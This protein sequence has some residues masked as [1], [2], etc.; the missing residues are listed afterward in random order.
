MAAPAWVFLPAPQHAASATAIRAAAV[1]PQT[2]TIPDLGAP[3][4]PG[5]SN[6]RPQAARATVAA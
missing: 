2:P 4:A 3:R 1:V 5:V 6:H